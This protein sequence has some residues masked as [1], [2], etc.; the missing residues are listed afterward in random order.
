[1]RLIGRAAF[2]LWI[3]GGVAVW[4]GEVAAQVP[5]W[6]TDEPG[7]YRAE[8]T[9][10]RRVDSDDYPA[11]LGAAAND[12]CREFQVPFALPPGTV[13]VPGVDDLDLT[14]A[15]TRA[16]GAPRYISGPNGEQPVPGAQMSH[17]GLDVGSR[18]SADGG[19]TLTTLGNAA[20]LPVHPGGYVRV[21]AGE[22]R[23]RIMC[24]HD[25]LRLVLESTTDT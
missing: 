13:I 19:A 20:V 22:L 2:V 10:W 12:C 18:V 24:E 11:D 4:E 16:P 3:L 25:G 21:A 15:R 1:M 9:E 14:D 8:G 5:S 17:C 23:Q 7:L 6:L